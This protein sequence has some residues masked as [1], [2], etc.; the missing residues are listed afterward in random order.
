MLQQHVLKVY[1]GNPLT[2]GLDHILGAIR[3][4]HVAPLV[5]HAHIAGAQ[6]AVLGKGVGLLIEI[7]AGDPGAFQLKLAHC[8]AILLEEIAFIIHDPHFNTGNRP[9][10]F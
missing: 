1:G 8:R 4:L 10:A 9:A 6:P 5:H 3:E 7:T 2:A